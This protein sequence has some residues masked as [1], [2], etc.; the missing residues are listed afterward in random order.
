M[1]SKSK[2]L[3]YE[4]SGS[5]IN[6]TRHRDTS[7]IPDLKKWTED[8]FTSSVKDHFETIAPTALKRK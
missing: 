7:L 6:I 2:F 8:V 3:F 4:Y 1:S 5:K